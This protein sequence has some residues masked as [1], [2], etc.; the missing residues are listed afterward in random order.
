[1]MIISNLFTIFNTIGYG[2]GVFLILSIVSMAFLAGI[3]MCFLTCHAFY[4]IITGFPFP[5]KQCN[6]QPCKCDDGHNSCLA[7]ALYQTDED[8]AEPPELPLDDRCRTFK[9]GLLVFFILVTV[10]VLIVKFIEYDIESMK[11]PDPPATGH[12][13]CVLVNMTINNYFM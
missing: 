12:T 1:M 8:I 4:S 10:I 9:D 7:D 13:E 5:I 2:L 6:G 11:L 3:G